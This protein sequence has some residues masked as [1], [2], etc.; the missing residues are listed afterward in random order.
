M[1]DLSKL[2]ATVDV[3]NA[4]SMKILW[5]TKS[6]QPLELLSNYKN[7]HKYEVNL[8]LLFVQRSQW[9]TAQW[10]AQNP[11][12]SLIVYKMQTLPSSVSTLISRRDPESITYQRENWELYL[13]LS[14]AVEHIQLSE[15][16]VNGQRI[17]IR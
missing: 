6:S 2:K 7:Y 4:V 1:M 14:T 9:V 15:F 3:Q 17:F 13:S 12:Q 16:L 8:A 10:F 11:R 5:S